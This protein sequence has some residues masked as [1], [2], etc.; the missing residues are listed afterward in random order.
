MTGRSV[1]WRWSTRRRLDQRPPGRAVYATSICVLDRAGPR[2]CVVVNLATRVRY[3]AVRGGEERD[4]ERLR[5]SGCGSWGGPSWTSRFPGYHPGWAQHRALGAARS[6][7]ARRRG[8][9]RRVPGRRPQHAVR[10][11]YLAGLL[12]CREAGAAEGERAGR[13]LVVRDASSRR[14]IVAATP[15]L[16]DRLAGEEGL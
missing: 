9:A 7:A 12:I 11:G 1:C 8:G 4:G 6:S 16:A 14:P 15:A 13:D 3:A 5:P 10:L 2:V